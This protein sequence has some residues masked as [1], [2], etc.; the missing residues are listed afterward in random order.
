MNA[1]GMQFNGGGVR[2]TRGRRHLRLA[3]VLRAHA[4][5]HVATLVPDDDNLRQMT[6]AAEWQAPLTAA[7]TVLPMPSQLR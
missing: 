6:S 5:E 3:P 7:P 2:H 1:S 4:T